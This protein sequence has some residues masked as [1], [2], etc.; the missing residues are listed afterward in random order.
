[1][2]RRIPHDVSA[3]K[4]LGYD[5]E[6]KDPHTEALVFIEVKGRWLGR[7]DITLTKNEILCSRNEPDKFRL[8]LVPVAEDG[9]QAPRYLRGFV[10]GEPDFAETTRTFSLRKLLEYAGEPV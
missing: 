3:Q 5:I 4:G 6:S 9:V 2:V 8:A 10:F 7:D 1:M